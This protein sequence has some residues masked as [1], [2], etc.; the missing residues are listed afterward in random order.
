MRSVIYSLDSNQAGL[1]T[2]GGTLAGSHRDGHG[3]NCRVPLGML[4]FATLISACSPRP[5][6]EGTA[7]DPPRPELDFTLVD[8]FG[9]PVEL[10]RLKG[11]VVVLT[12]LYTRCTELCPLVTRKIRHAIDLLAEDSRNVEVLAVTVDPTHDDVAAAS[13]Y[14]RKWSLLARWRFLTGGAAELEPVWRYYWVGQIRQEGAGTPD[15]GSAPDDVEH[16]SPVHLIDQTGRVR[17]VYGNDF[18]PEALV[19]D[20]RV[21]LHH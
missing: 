13:A 14:S 7:L 8:Q 5:A 3:W 10:A 20:I 18:Q 15:G 21:L 17:V 19:H 6:F 12:F 4:L 2:N 11:R 16:M 1:D 9:Q